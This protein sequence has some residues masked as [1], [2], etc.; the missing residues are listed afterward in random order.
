MAGLVRSIHL[1]TSRRT[2]TDQT[3]SQKWLCFLYIVA[4]LLLK[5]VVN[6]VQLIANA[7]VSAL[8]P[9]SRFRA[10]KVLEASNVAEIVTLRI[11][12]LIVRSYRRIGCP[13]VVL[14]ALSRVLLE[15]VSF[16]LRLSAAAAE[17]NTWFSH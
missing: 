16:A 5:R 13:I 17:L 12:G 3:Q 9:A 6:H 2:A 4:H 1:G 15:D 14:A 11:G 8:Q 7:D 10:L